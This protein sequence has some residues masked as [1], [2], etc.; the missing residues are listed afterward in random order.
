MNTNVK[1]TFTIAVILSIVYLGL[2]SNVKSNI[3]SI[4]INATNSKECETDCN[5]S[6]DT[7]SK[8]KNNVSLGIALS[9]LMVFGMIAFGY[10]IYNVSKREVAVIK[11][12]IITSGLKM[13]KKEIGSGG[14]GDYKIVFK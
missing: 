12:L 1:I 11:R 13:P 6:F 5:A 4:D 14:K 2:I 10:V 9:V 8:I 3:S 7:M